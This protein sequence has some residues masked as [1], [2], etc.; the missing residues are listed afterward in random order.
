MAGIKMRLYILTKTELYKTVI[1]NFY[2]IEL[3]CEGEDFT[4]HFLTFIYRYHF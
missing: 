2:Y 4:Y 3:S 1:T